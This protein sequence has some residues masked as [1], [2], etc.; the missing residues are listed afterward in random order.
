MC[1]GDEN[2]NSV[3]N[4]ASAGNWPGCQRHSQ[5]TRVVTDIELS[6][7][8]RR[9]ADADATSAVRETPVRHPSR[10]D[11]QLRTIAVRPADEV[12]S[13]THPPR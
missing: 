1:I 13:V 11:A 4:Q 12:V 7:R 10:W 2:D 9:S 5:R 6:S 3:L 8:G